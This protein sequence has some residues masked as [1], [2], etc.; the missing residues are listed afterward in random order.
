MH[1]TPEQNLTNLLSRADQCHQLS[2]VAEQ[3][4]AHIGN[5]HEATHPLPRNSDVEVTTEVTDDVAKPLGSGPIDREGS[6]S[7]FQ[8]IDDIVKVGAANPPHMHLDR[9]R[10]LTHRNLS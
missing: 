1:G 6:I 10:L 3:Q 9:R 8:Q 7:S 5:V 2:S 4:I